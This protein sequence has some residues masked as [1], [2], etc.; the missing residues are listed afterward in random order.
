VPVRWR[1]SHF[2][3]IAAAG[4]VAARSL[5]SANSSRTTPSQFGWLRSSCDRGNCWRRRTRRRTLYALSSKTTIR[6][7][8]QKTA[9][10]RKNL[11]DRPG[12][13]RVAFELAQPLPVVPCAREISSARG[14]HGRLPAA[15]GAFAIAAE[16]G[17]NPVCPH[18][19]ATAYRLTEW[20]RPTKATRPRGAARSKREL[21]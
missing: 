20:K 17:K 3:R 13:A 12:G 10:N 15:H 16:S 4:E 1:S 2:W 8:V 5:A 7:G 6:A 19:R 9:S 21:R 11:Q 14:G 18:Y